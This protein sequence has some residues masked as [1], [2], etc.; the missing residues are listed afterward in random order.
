MTV[1]I[2]LDPAYSG[3]K[4]LADQMPVWAVDSELNREVAERLW[5]T[6]GTADA[7][8]GITLFKVSDERD[9][10]GNCANIIGEV[11]L[12]HG[13]YSSGLKVATLTVI[14]ASPSSKLLRE[15]GV[16]GFAN[17]EPTPDGFVARAE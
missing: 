9:A 5:R 4:L 16:Y 12:H 8:R 7:F 1:A 10:E 3:L 6:H 14:G 17:F 15:L 11:G 2:V 13:I